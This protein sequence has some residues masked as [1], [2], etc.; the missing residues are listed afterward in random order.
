MSRPEACTRQWDLR[1]VVEAC[2]LPVGKAPE[3]Q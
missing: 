3:R 1:Y 2:S